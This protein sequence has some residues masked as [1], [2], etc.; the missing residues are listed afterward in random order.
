M[1]ATYLLSHSFCGSGVQAWIS[2]V[3]CFRNSHTVCGLG[4]QSHLK[5]CL[6]KDPLPS[7]C[8]VGRIQF[9]KCCWTEGLSALLV[10]GQRLFLVPCVM[11]SWKQHPD[12]FAILYWLKQVIGPVDIQGKGIIQGH[13][14]Q[15]AR[16]MGAHLRTRPSQAVK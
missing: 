14:Y 12:T 7:S 3:L 1:L 11:Q 8:V 16:V 6:G 13:E 15:T 10:I 4:L 2:W 5:T 9:L